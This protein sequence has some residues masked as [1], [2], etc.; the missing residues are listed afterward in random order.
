MF[1]RQSRSECV[2][3]PLKPGWLPCFIGTNNIKIHHNSVTRSQM[4]WAT[5][6][7]STCVS[8]HLTWIIY[9]VS[10]LHSTFF[11][12]TIMAQHATIPEFSGKDQLSYQEKLI[13]FEANDIDSCAA[14]EQWAILLSLIE[15]DTYTLLCSMVV[16]KSPLKLSCTA[17]CTL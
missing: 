4:E 15:T 17:L 1:T 12:V 9:T 14:T 10:L 8:T 7:I 3:F 13:Y 6:E 5:F 16:P 2:C 11:I